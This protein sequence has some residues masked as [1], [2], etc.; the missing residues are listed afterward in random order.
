MKVPMTSKFKIGEAV[1]VNL[2]IAGIISGVVDAVKFTENPH[3]VLYDIKVFPFANEEGNEHHHI[4]LKDIHGYYIEE[5]FD[6]FKLKGKTNV[7]VV[8]F[9][10]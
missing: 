3:Q 7:G 8:S 2:A 1:V 5:A 9:N 4:I 6:R 10:N